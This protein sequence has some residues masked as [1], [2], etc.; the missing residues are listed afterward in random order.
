MS[1]REMLL[2]APRFRWIMLIL[3]V[4]AYGQF[5]LTVQIPYAFSTYIMADLSLSATQVSLFT[6]TIL[7]MFAFTGSLGAKIATR[8]GLRKCVALGIMTN[9]AGALLILILARSFPGYLV[10]CAIHGFSGGIICSSMISSTTLWF[11]V[12][13]RG[14]ATGILLGILGVGFSIATFFAPRLISSG[15]SWQ[16]SA[17]LLT[18]IPGAVIAIIYFVFA[19]QVDEVYPGHGSV[20]EMLP[21]V[22]QQAASSKDEGE[23]PKTMTTLYHTRTFWFAA[24]CAFISG[25][26]SYGFPAFISG[27]LIQDKGLSVSLATS[28]ASVTFFVTLFGSPLGGIISDSVFKGKRWQ[29]VALGSVMIAVMLLIAAFTTG[30]A[31][32]IALVL[33]YMA[34]SMCVGPY[35]A[36]PAALV[37]PSIAN[38]SAGILNVF[39]NTGGFT[40]GFILTALAAWA[41]TYYICLYVSVALAVVSAICITFVRR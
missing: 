12:R 15:L 19:K 18:T 39:G 13:Q 37:H 3:N 20:A 30:P 41:G 5:F 26:M 10:C 34:S 28:V 25:C 24:A 36:I 2:N 32:T 40:I 33:A 6:T 11:P 35:W 9:I 21:S 23:L 8:V 31:L 4:F 1:E 22:K 14:L 7:G 38:D 27:F 17:C 29:T 16:I